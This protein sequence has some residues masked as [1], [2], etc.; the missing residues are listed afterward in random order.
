MPV[1]EFSFPPFPMSKKLSVI[2]W[3]AW[4]YC[5]NFLFI[6]V[7]SHWPGLTD[8]QGRLLGLFAID[9][10]DDI[11]HLISGLLAGVVAFKS[12]SWSVNYFKYAGI[13]YAV[14]AITGILFGVEFLN[15]DVFTEGLHR[16]DFSL[17]TVLRNGPHI[18]IPVTMLWIGFWLA[19][20]TD[21]P[22]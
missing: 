15:G 22:A 17:Q 4:F 18:L 21:K 14:D 2:Q 19:K 20:R 11:F 7:L 5:A 6:V 12:R 10:V 1:V 3:L 13:P 9:P 8:A 16:A